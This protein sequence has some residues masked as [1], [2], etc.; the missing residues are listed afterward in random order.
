MERVTAW[1]IVLLGC[2]LLQIVA[3]IQGTSS[4]L[5]RQSASV[6]AQLPGSSPVRAEGRHADAAPCQQ[7][8]I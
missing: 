5:C 2:C 8:H 7:E 6:S 3:R 4:A 1:C